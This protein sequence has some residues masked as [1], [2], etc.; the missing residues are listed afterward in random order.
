VRI[1]QGDHGNLSYPNYLDLRAQ[2]KTLQGF[3]AFSWPI[4][5]ALSDASARDGA[6]ADQVWSAAVSANYFDVLGVRV[7]HGRAFLP[8]EEQAAGSAPV[9]VLGDALWRTR[10]QADPGVV[11]RTVRINGRPFQVIGIARGEMPQ[12][13]ALFAHQL[14]VPAVMCDQVGIG[15]RLANRKNSWLRTIGRLGDGRVLSELRA[16]MPVIARAIEAAAP[17]EARGL[18]FTPDWETRAR[19]AGMPGA[20][21]MG[22]ILQA[23]V[24][25]V[26]GIACVNIANL[27]L[28]RRSSRRRE[29][30]TR[31]AIGAGRGRI[32]RQLLTESLLLTLC[33]GGLGLV[34]AQW[35]SRLL[36]ALAPPLP[37]GMPLAVDVAPDQRVLAFG[38]LLSLAIGLVFGLATALGP[39][40]DGLHALLKSGGLAARRARGFSPRRTLVGAQVAL[41][42]VLLVT[43]LLFL[44]S[45]GNANRIHLGFR[46]ENR[47]ALSVSPRMVRYTD[48][49]AQRLHDEALRRLG[50]L[51]GVVSASSTLMLPLSGGYLGDGYVWPEGDLEPSERGR[52]M[53][54][55]DRV[56]PGYFATMGAT[57]L[58]GREFTE[59]DR[60]GASSVA[61]VN[62]TF[63]ARFWPGQPALGRRFRTSARGAL[64]EVVGVVADGRYNRLGEDPQ[65]HVYQPLLQASV[66]SGF[67]VVLWTSD[68]PRG[69]AA[70]ARAALQGLDPDV[71]VGP[72]QTLAEHLRMAFWGPRVGATLLGGFA[73]LGIV[74]SAAGLYGVLSFV[75]SRSA[76]EIGV[77]MALGA[78][79]AGLLGLFVRRGLGMAA[80][81][82]VVG[83]ALAAAAARAVSSHLY[84]VPAWN[85]VTFAGV[86][87]LLL[88]VT[89]AASYLPSRR[90]VKVDPARALRQD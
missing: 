7:Q 38:L 6:R 85:P 9:V 53:V 31:M 2:T 32:V 5:V 29:I 46:P 39:S 61:V 17:E 64:V 21:R 68:D 76:T 49:Q 30:A 4:P 24:A 14:W 77:R 11:G 47:L 56:G 90:A 84:G 26:L 18:R 23:V 66:A 79:P 75:V 22:W 71:P 43:A 1:Y 13:E 35:G 58:R 69:V 65:R 37:A 44:E 87:I 12:P 45:L 27:Q 50:E 54:Y 60:V 40:R 86:A 81:G 10:F 88:A 3:A 63:A 89:M 16:E 74:L 70:A 41:S 28:A 51:P 25:V 33:G 57:L 59:Q 20:R 48:A 73:A 19:L 80:G 8:A 67:N 36:L 83:L 34:A 55:F 78:P 52:P 62:E 15:D 72:P 42:A 82:I